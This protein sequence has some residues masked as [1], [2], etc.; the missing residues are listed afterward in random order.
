MHPV[1]NIEISEITKIVENA[2]KYLQISF[3][4]DLYLYC[5]ESDINFPEL[6]DTPNTKWNVYI[7]QP[8]EEIRGLSSK[9]YEDV[10]RIVKSKEK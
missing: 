5:Q 2:H 8:R 3:A 10:Y 6:R 1:A 7:L 4:E 9:R